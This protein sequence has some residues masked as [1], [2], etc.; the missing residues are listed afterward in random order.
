MRQ[1]FRWYSTTYHTP[2]HLVEDLPLEDVLCHYYEA[3]ICERLEEKERLKE[4]IERS[5]ENPEQRNERE[6][7][8]EM[9]CE[10]GDIGDDAFLEQIEK[11]A[12]E[13]KLK[14]KK[15]TRTHNVE[16]VEKPIPGIKWQPPTTNESDLPMSLFPEENIKKTTISAAEMEDLMNMDS[17]MGV[18]PK[19]QS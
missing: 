17:L 13:A 5:L 19:K 9:D 7:Q 6:R 16:T 1:I 14:P 8:E 18:V 10:E 11:E 15:G 2:L 12:A 4:F 3:N